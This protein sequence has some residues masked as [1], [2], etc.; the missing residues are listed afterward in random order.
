MADINDH[1]LAS[2][3]GLL[4]SLAVGFLH[5][6]G[7]FNAGSHV[8][9]EV[10]HVE[11]FVIIV[12]AIFGLADIEQ[13]VRS[14][15]KDLTLTG[16]LDHIFVKQSFFEAIGGN[17]QRQTVVEFDGVLAS[18]FKLLLFQTTVAVL[19]HGNGGAQEAALVK[20]LL[21]FGQANGG[22]ESGETEL[23]GDGGIVS[24]VSAGL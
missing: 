5:L 22:K 17:L 2:F 18:D 10:H 6:L 21:G 8:S 4:A 3:P 9:G 1:L 19:V 15:G 20:N 12:V 16:V 14:L 7:S 24:R 13:D 23:H 11:A